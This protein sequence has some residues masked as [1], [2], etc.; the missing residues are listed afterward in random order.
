[1][2]DNMGYLHSPFFLMSQ[3]VRKDVFED[4][5]NNNKYSKEETIG[6][7]LLEDSGI[8]GTNFNKILKP[9]FSKREYVLRQIEEQS[10]SGIEK[11]EG[12]SKKIKN[13]VRTV[14]EDMK[15]D[16]TFYQNTVEKYQAFLEHLTKKSSKIARCR[17]Y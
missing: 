10:V 7:V 17:C 9:D 3:G 8:G 6:V 13:F 4:F 1:M 11:N 12:Y 16:E 5:L 2:G 15:T 14:F